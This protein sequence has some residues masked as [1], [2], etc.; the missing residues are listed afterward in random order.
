MIR[1]FRFIKMLARTVFGLLTAFLT[2]AT[3]STNQSDEDDLSEGA[4]RGGL[5]NY[6]TGKLDDGTDPYGWYE[7]D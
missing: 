1:F 4:F 5:L 3:E 6:R 2:L 7:E